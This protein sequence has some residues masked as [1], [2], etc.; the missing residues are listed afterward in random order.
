MIS[1]FV[2]TDST[3]YIP[4]YN[5]KR[6]QMPHIVSRYKQFILLTVNLDLTI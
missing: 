2:K 5:N 3:A 4:K 1:D 6:N